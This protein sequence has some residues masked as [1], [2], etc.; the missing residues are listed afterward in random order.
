GG[1]S[2]ALVVRRRTADPV[3]DLRRGLALGEDAHAEA[4]GPRG[5]VPL[6]LPPRVADAL[7]VAEHRLGLGREAR[8]HHHEVT[9]QVDDVVYVL[10][11]HGALVDA[12]TARDAV[13]DHLLGH[14]RVDDR[15]QLAAREQGRAFGED[16]VTHAHDHELRREQFAG[17][18]RRTDV[19]AAPAL[20]AGERVD[21][22]LP[23]EVADRSG[24]EAHLGFGHVEAQRLE[25]AAAPG[26]G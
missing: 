14:R 17:G 24:A 10:D 26:A 8:L 23:G 15:R 25:A 16:L 22:L 7:D 12:G 2:R 1:R 19:L 18:I 11:R 9:A 20:G 3:E 4:L 21:H 13:P 6:R 5:A